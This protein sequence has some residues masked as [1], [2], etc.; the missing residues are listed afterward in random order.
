MGFRLNQLRPLDSSPF[1]FLDLINSSFACC[2]PRAGAGRAEPP[3][4]QF[5]QFSN[6]ASGFYPRFILVEGICQTKPV[7]LG[8]RAPRSA[9]DLANCDTIAGRFL[10]NVKITSRY[11][12]RKSDTFVILYPSHLISDINLLE[13]PLPPR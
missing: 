10:R 6:M 12:R 5:L 13:N 2:L 4:P 9:S 8:K 1:Q 11:F 3:L 7:S